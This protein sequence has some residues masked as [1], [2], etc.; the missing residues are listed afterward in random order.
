MLMNYQRILEEASDK[1]T[2]FASDIGFVA[3][4]MA[5]S[6]SHR[7]LTIEYFNLIVMPALSVGQLKVYFDDAGDPVGYV[8]WATVANDVEQRFLRSREPRLHASEWNEGESLWILDFSVIS[9]QGH[10]K[11][12][13][14]QMRDA[15]F[16]HHARVRYFKIK[17]NLRYIK[18]IE[19]D[20]RLSFFAGGP[21]WIS[22]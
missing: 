13:L 6:R 20:N 12:V 1:A 22:K 10:I 3:Y 4:L 11:H 17:R 8:I 5:R 18:E 21:S 2:K 19:R 16:L 14:C 7:Q 15:L 9:G